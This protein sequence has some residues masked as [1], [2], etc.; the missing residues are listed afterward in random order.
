MGGLAV[1][2][3]PDS[4]KGVSA[5]IIIYCFFYNVTI[6]ATA[7]AILTEVST[8]RLRVKTIAIGSALQNAIFVSSHRSTLACY[9]YLT[10]TDN[11]VIRLPLPLQSGPSQPRRKDIFHLRWFGDSM[12]VIFMD[13][14]AGDCW[15]DV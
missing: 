6:G 14:S 3:T 11:V 2:N 4:L 7:Y 10:S 13:L 5:L 12:F 15:Q 9:K 1:A 8:G